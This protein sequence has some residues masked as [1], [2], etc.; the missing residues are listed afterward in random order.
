M[1]ISLQSTNGPIDHSAEVS[2]VQWTQRIDEVYKKVNDEEGKRSYTLS[3]TLGLS[4]SF[5]TLQVEMSDAI[6]VFCKLESLYSESKNIDIQNACYQALEKYRPLIQE[7]NHKIGC[8]TP[9]DV[10]GALSF[11]VP[12]KN[13]YYTVD[14]IQYVQAN[15]T[16]AF[17][18]GS[19]CFAQF[20]V[21]E[22]MGFSRHCKKN[23]KVF[24][25][26][27]V[28]SPDSHF[29]RIYYSDRH[30]LFLEKIEKLKKQVNPT[31]DQHLS[32]WKYSNCEY[33]DPY[34]LMDMG[35]EKD[36]IS[37]T[38]GVIFYYIIHEEKK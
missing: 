38:F 11:V 1:A 16:E 22:E 27:Y 10:Q 15:H 25:L 37:H 9:L 14:G 19:R 20:E 18:F 35:F 6:H 33:C 26:L 8:V 32:K 23:G 31:F 21:G 12:P 36:L 34:I 3:K 24:D 2:I 4:P 13:L 17:K 7:I 28:K 30:K 29:S 5:S